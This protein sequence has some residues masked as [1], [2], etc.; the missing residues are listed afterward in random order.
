MIVRFLFLFSF[1]PVSREK[2]RGIWLNEIKNGE[3]DRWMAVQGKCCAQRKKHSLNNGC[4]Y[5]IICTAGMASCCL[6]NANLFLNALTLGTLC[7][8]TQKIAISHEFYTKGQNNHKIDVWR[9]FLVDVKSRS[10]Y[11]K[12]ICN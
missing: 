1:S 7:N 12:I 9:C 2:W 6:H 5:Y 11:E 10:N 8:F 3:V 4:M